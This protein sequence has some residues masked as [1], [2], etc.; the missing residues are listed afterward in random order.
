VLL[1]RA[2]Q[3]L[4]VDEATTYNKFVSGPWRKAVR[5]LRREQPYSKLASGQSDGHHRRFSEFKLRLPSLIA[6]LFLTLGV[7]LAAETGRIA[8]SALGRVRGNLLLP[9]APRFLDR[10]ARLQPQPGIFVWALYFCL[11]RRYLLAGFFWAYRWVRNLAILFPVLAVMLIVTPL[12]KA[13]KALAQ[14]CN[15][16]VAPWRAHQWSLAQE[17][18]RGDF[19]IGYS[20]FRTAAISF[21]ATSLYARPGPGR[22]FGCTRRSHRAPGRLR[23][24]SVF[25]RRRSS[26]RSDQGSPEAHSVSYGWQSHCSDSAWLAGC[27]D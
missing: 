2:H 5:T 12:R 1:S 19:Y 20:D 17:G 8:E 10:S 9:S 18:Q 22:N 11:Q 6:G 13:S 24:A 14:P 7:F 15:S 27:L 25:D 4:I 23:I 26:I 21:V 16:R 3:A